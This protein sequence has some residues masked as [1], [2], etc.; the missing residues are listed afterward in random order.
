[1]PNSEIAR[2]YTARDAVEA[3]AVRSELELRGIEARV[4]GDLLGGAVGGLPP[5]HSTSP[6]IWVR[7]EDREQAGKVIER[8]FSD[9][10]FTWDGSKQGEKKTDTETGDDLA[11]RALLAAMLGIT[12][13]PVLSSGYSIWLLMRIARQRYP[14]SPTGNWHINAA[15]VLNALVLAVLLLFGLVFYI[16]IAFGF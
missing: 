6:E 15:L 2:V 8:F 11:A 13:V 5:G 1:M 9:P 16:A 7:G 12:L 3:T 10:S 14:V 4:V